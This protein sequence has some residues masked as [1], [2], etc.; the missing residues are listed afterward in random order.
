MAAKKKVVDPNEV[1]HLQPKV[2]EV[3]VYNDV[4][5]GD[6][7]TLQVRRGDLNQVDGKFEEVDP[8]KVPDAAERG[9]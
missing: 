6:R 4:A 8:D 2:G 5:F 1:V 7:A 3:V 9:G